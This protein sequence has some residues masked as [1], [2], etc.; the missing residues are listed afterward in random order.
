MFLS[1]SFFICNIALG[2]L[3]LRNFKFI[4][5]KKVISIITG[6]LFLSSCDNS[7]E[8]PENEVPET[9][10]NLTEMYCPEVPNT[11]I[12]EGAMKESL[13]LEAILE[14]VSGQVYKMIAVYNCFE[15]NDSTFYVI[16]PRGNIDNNLNCLYGLIGEPTRFLSIEKDYTIEWKEYVGDMP[17]AYYRSYS[18]DKEKQI[19]RDFVQAGYSVKEFKIQYADKNCLILFADAVCDEREEHNAIAQFSRIV[20]QSVNKSEVPDCDIIDKRV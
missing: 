12:A 5:M 7:A 15:R 4:N 18:Y 19:F 3:L 2:L 6:I 9:T 14:T 20:Y 10:A 17:E 8:I 13:S 1:C 11:H 16:Q